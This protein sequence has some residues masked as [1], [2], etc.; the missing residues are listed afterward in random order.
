M[1]IKQKIYLI[2]GLFLVAIIILMLGVV[3]PLALEIKK[4]SAS[5]KE[6]REKLL[7]LEKT[8]QNYLRQ[9]ELDYKEINDNLFSAKSG[10]IDGAQAVNFFM[11]LEEV[12]Y[13]VSNRLEIKA[14]EFPS[15]TLNLMGS[16]PNLM[17]FSGWLESGKYFLDV[18]SIQIKRISEGETIE[19]FS[20]GDV[21]S[22]IKIKLYTKK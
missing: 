9:V 4:A 17:R 21:K 12:A 20:A 3:K 13:S 8:D 5:A 18:D 14:T 2:S 6:S 16:F 22:T 15:I 7:L 10:L 1:N 19:G 11:A